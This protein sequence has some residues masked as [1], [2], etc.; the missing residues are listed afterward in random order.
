MEPT[1]KFEM[2]TGTQNTLSPWTLPLWKSINHDVLLTPGDRPLASAPPIGEV[3]TSPLIVMPIPIPPPSNPQPVL[4]IP[5]PP[6]S[7]PQQ[8]Q[9][10]QQQ[11][12]AQQQQQ[13][14]QQQQLHQ[15][16]GNKNLNQLV[17][18]LPFAADGGG[19]IV[20]GQDPKLNIGTSQLLQPPRPHSSSFSPLIQFPKDIID[21]ISIASSP[22]TTTTSL[23]S[24]P[25]PSSSS[26]L[27]QPSKQAQ[28]IIN[29][30]QNVIPE[31]CR[32]IRELSK[33]VFA[34]DNS[35][36]LQGQ[37]AA[38]N[39]GASST[40][41]SSPFS[42]PY[43]SRPMS[44]SETSLPSLPYAA[45]LSSSTLFSQSIVP[46]IPPIRSSSLATATGYASSIATSASTSSNSNSGTGTGTSTSNGTATAI[47]T[48]N[49]NGIRSSPSLGPISFSASL[50]ELSIRVKC[51]SSSGSFYRRKSDLLQ[52]VGGRVRIHAQNAA[53]GK[54]AVI[55]ITPIA[56]DAGGHMPWEEPVESMLFRFL[57]ASLPLLEEM[58]L[59]NGD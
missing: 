27:F 46:I 22:S 18:P 21:N 49:S 34:N 29:L 40:P 31:L 43:P 11:Y 10:V 5:I 17:L 44:P 37:C 3:W 33:E 7:N 8:Q 54:P 56:V 30:Q 51:Y 39:N 4:P 16:Y 15:F 36:L 42:S 41:S 1:R 38:V 48:G 53:P 2:S 13:F 52:L 59:D 9:S 26:Y 32:A 14:A 19:N 25:L 12:S 55:R 58:G 35:P 47:A 45:T 57:R 6:P 50:T 28:L 23:S 24:S 20:G